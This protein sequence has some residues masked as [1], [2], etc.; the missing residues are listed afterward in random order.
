[1]TGVG[2]VAEL[3]SC[4]APRIGV[5]AELEQLIGFGSS[6]PKALWIWITCQRRVVGDSGSLPGIGRNEA[7]LW[8][9]TQEGGTG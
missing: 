6:R 7:P 5:R 3:V 4:G 2:G 1:M 8:R 9:G